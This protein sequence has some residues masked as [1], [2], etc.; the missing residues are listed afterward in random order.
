MDPSR[1]REG[2][3]SGE[4]LGTPVLGSSC[5]SWKVFADT[6]L[7]LEQPR[8]LSC[9]EDATER[10]APLC[11]WRLRSGVLGPESMSLL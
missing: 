11:L 8:L 9:A 6:H 4:P 1:G 5:K 10:I 7:P 3:E 2:A